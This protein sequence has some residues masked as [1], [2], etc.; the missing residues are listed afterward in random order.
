MLVRTEIEPSETRASGPFVTIRAGGPLEGVV[1][2]TAIGQSRGRSRVDASWRE[3]AHV[4]SQSL[5][6]SSYRI[7]RVIAHAA[8]RRFALGE[9]PLLSRDVTTN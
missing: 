2:I 4:C 3:G 1:T 6:S 8:A 7:A 9:P 5:E